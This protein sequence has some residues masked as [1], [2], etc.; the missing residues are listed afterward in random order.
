MEAV[1]LEVPRRAS[2]EPATRS[3][4]EEWSSARAAGGG[5]TVERPLPCGSLKQDRT[6]DSRTADNGKPPLR[7]NGCLVPRPATGWA[8]R[9]KLNEFRARAAPARGPVRW[10]PHRYRR[11]SDNR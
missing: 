6:V 8:A 3:L 5:R 10:R 7:D 1:A 9:R 2:V 4:S 11:T